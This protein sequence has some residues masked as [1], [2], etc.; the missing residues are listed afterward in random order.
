M[1]KNILFLIFI[2]FLFSNYTFSNEL[3]NYFPD[4]FIP[5]NLKT[6]NVSEYDKAVSEKI[7]KHFLANYNIA[8]HNDKF[9]VKLWNIAGP[10]INFMDLS[11]DSI[12]I[13]MITSKGF[14]ILSAPDG[15]IYISEDTVNFCQNDDEIAFLLGRELYFIKNEIKNNIMKNTLISENLRNNEPVVTEY[16]LSAYSLN[17]L[18]A[19]RKSAYYIFKTGHSPWNAHSFIKRFVNISKENSIFF[20]NSKIPERIN[21]LSNYIKN[22]MPFAHVKLENT[23]NYRNTYYY[24]ILG[25]KFLKAN[26]LD[27]SINAY[28][29][30]ISLN[31]KIAET[32]NNIGIA[33]AKRGFFQE[34]EYHY[35]IAIKLQPDYRYYFNHAIT[36]IKLG[37]N[38]KALIQLKR[39]ISHNPSNEKAQKLYFSLETVIRET[40]S[41]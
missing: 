1:K 30:S 34:A 16:F 41:L 9:L 32:H 26:L 37:Q 28:K 19:D 35:D 25:N 33:Y 12:D 18:E 21:N 39:S 38:N 3:K 2:L 13:Q 27:D 23:S 20:D 8:D 4:K 14:L 11:Y 24:F 22:S 31:P 17:T 40:E 15:T 6:L 29:L 36:L 5:K 7:K 10:I